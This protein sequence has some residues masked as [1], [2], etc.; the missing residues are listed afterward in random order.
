[1]QFQSSGKPDKQYIILEQLLQHY[2]LQRGK[3]LDSKCLLVDSWYDTYLVVIL[4]RVIDEKI[5]NI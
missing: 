5:T 3:V 4:V 1:M 2:Q